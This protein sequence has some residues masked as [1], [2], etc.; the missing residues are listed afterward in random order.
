MSPDYLDAYIEASFSKIA[1]FQS[2]DFV[3][4]MTVLARWV[5]GACIMFAVSYDLDVASS[6]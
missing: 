2:S 4:S 1:S 6:G 5:A 3:N